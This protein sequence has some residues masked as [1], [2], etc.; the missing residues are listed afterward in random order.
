[1]T[2]AQS[3]KCSMAAIEGSDIDLSVIAWCQLRRLSKYG[4]KG[5]FV[6]LK[7]S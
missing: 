3:M 1:M 2:A 4:I 5:L 6:P 7:I